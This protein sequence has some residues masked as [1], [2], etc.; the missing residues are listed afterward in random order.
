MCIGCTLQN[1]I[2]KLA[3]T[4]PKRISSNLSWNTR[5]DFLKIPSLWEAALETERRCFSNV[6]LESNVTLNISR[7]SDSFSTVPSMVNGGWLGM[8]CAW[9]GDYHSLGLT[10]I[11]FH[12]PKVTPRIH[13]DDV[14]VQGLCYCNS[15]AWGSIK[16]ES[17]A[18][19]LAYSPEWKKVPRC[20]EGTITCP[21]HCP[22]ALLTQHWPVYCDIHPPKHTVID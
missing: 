10:R 8:H 19:Q 4:N 11:Q 13:S 5:Q 22:T 9:P 2:P 12:Q 17:S 16:V 18:Y 20:T 3:R 7:S 14:T 1:S 21:K 15:S 6:N